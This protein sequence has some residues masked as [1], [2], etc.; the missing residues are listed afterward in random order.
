MSPIRIFRIDAKSRGKSVLFY[1]YLTKI[2]KSLHIIKMYVRLLTNKS[3]EVFT[4]TLTKQTAAYYYFT[5]AFTFFAQVFC[6]VL[7]N[8]YMGS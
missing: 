7:K 4:M 3:H 2:K 1:R 8:R 6:S 5:G